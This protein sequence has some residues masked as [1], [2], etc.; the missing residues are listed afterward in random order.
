MTEHAGGGLLVIISGPSGAGKSSIC[1][2]VLAEVDAE[3]SVSATTRAPRPG[4]VNGEDYWFLDREDFLA[5]VQA[6]YFAEHAT[7]CGHLYGTPLRP[8]EA[9]IEQGRTI[10][11]EIE[12]EGAA[13]IRRRFPGAVSIFIAPPSAEVAV[14]RLEKRR[15]NTPEDIARRNEQARMELSRA[16]EYDYVVVNDD[17]DAAVAEVKKILTKERAKRSGAS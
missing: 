2:R 5:K 16:G 17:L 14:Q 4:E 6:G 11:L 12:V 8:L 15:Q 9:A 13:Q 3:V 10:L 1:A 7:Y